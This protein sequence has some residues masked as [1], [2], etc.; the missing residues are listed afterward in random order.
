MS[1]DNSVKDWLG[2]KNQ[3]IA[4]V[5]EP[6]T[7]NQINSKQIESYKPNRKEFNNDIGTLNHVQV[8][9]FGED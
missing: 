5:L 9:I 8:D 4:E 6:L 1:E 7:V 3:E 2:R